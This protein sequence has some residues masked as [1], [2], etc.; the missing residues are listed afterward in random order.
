MASSWDPRPTVFRGQVPCAGGGEVGGRLPQLYEV[1]P[2]LQ[3]PPV[4]QL[5]QA[6]RFT[7]TRNATA[8]SVRIAMLTPNRLALTGD[9]GKGT[10]PGAPRVPRVL[11]WDLCGARVVIPPLARFVMHCLT[12]RVR[13][14]TRAGPCPDVALCR[15]KLYSGPPSNLKH[16]LLR[17]TTSDEPSD[18]ESKTTHGS[19]TILQ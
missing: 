2:L 12:G 9:L 17:T 10:R 13:T 6:Q 11:Q 15:R 1:F 16:K 14:N 18:S 19:E 7:H 5:S 3:G 8:G 4:S